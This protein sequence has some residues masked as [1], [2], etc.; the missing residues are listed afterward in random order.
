MSCEGSWT[1][2]LYMLFSEMHAG[3]SNETKIATGIRLLTQEGPEPSQL[4][5]RQMRMGR[6]HASVPEST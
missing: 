5:W 3:R 2:A 4:T 6:H 1:L